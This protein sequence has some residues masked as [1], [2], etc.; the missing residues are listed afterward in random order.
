MTFIHDQI[1][2]INLQFQKLLNYSG[3]KEF[4]GKIL[5]KL[6]IDTLIK[7]YH[8]KPELIFNIYRKQNKKIYELSND[9]Y[10]NSI[11]QYKEIYDSYIDHQKKFLENE[12]DALY[13]EKDLFINEFYKSIWTNIPPE[14]YFLFNSL[15]LSDIYF[16][17]AEYEKQIEDLNNKL[18]ENLN[19]ERFRS[20]LEGLTT[21]KN[22]LSPHHKKVIDFLDKKFINIFSNNNNNN[23]NLTPM[24][25]EEKEKNIENKNLPILTP[26]INKN[27][28]T[29][30][31]FQYLFYPRILLSKEDALYVQKIIDI[32]I[33]SPGNT[34]NTIDIMNKIPKFLLKIIICVTESEAENIGIFLNAFLNMIQNYQ[35]EKTWEEKCKK[36]ISFSRKLEEVVL[37]E[38]KDFKNA[39]NE[40]VKKV[41]YSIEKMIENEKEIS[42]IRNIIVMINK[43]SIIPPTKEVASSFFKI[44]TEIKKKIKNF[45]LLESYINVLAK[46]FKLDLDENNDNNNEINNEN[47]N[48]KK[49]KENINNNN[50]RN[51]NY[52]RNNIKRDRDR[53][54]TSKKSLGRNHDREH[55]RRERDRSRNRDMEKSKERIKERSRD[56]E[57]DKR[58]DKNFDTKKYKSDRNKKK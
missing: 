45:I 41:T 47:D 11:K 55:R 25:I 4:F 15:E 34:I 27:E 35:E 46:K 37:V 44:L 16:P 14:F 48:N 8:F 42:N 19:S 26:I 52:N 21:E 23:N 22:N 13:V 54:H 2:L 40:V 51:N 43:T 1:Y 10:N 20:E 56:R 53:S 57:R 12:F 31:L 6:D 30:N 3:K 32:L 28:L 29:K 50:D 7:K 17:K 33:L 5:E 36:N 49:E 18:Q 58:D 39:F 24:I 9:E 38:L